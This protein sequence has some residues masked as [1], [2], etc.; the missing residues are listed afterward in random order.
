MTAT[1]ILRTWPGW[2]TRS[3][4]VSETS[5]FCR[6]RFWF[7]LRWCCSGVAAD[8]A[9]RQVARH[10]HARRRPLRALGAL[11]GLGADR[12]PAL[13]VDG[14]LGDGL[15]VHVGV[16]VDL[17]DRPALARR[18][19]RAAA[20]CW[21]AASR[22]GS[23]GL[24]APPFSASSLPAS[25]TPRAESITAT[26]SGATPGHRRGHQV[27]DRLGLAAV[28][29]A[30]RHRHGDRGRAGRGAGERLRDRVR[31]VDAGGA[32]VRRA[33]DGA[34]ELALLGAPVGGVEHLAGGAEAREVVED[35]VAGRPAGRQPLGGQRHADRGR[36]R[37]GRPGSSCRRPRRRRPRPRARRPPRRRRRSRD[38]SRA[39]PSTARSRPG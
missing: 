23:F 21:R 18:A 30:A 9:V 37:R 12:H 13:G 33:G 17:D 27:A 36:A 29:L 7:E 28:E 8:V 6:S 10:R 34:G 19:P 38:R 1:L 24:P 39:S 20:G 2:I 22:R 14:A 4:R 5:K 11:L 3:R 32:H 16:D 35:L 26:A 31:Q 15:A 25:T